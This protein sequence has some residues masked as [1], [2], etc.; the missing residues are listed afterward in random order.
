MN[1]S[2]K[3]ASRRNSK[4]GLHCTSF[5]LSWWLVDCHIL[6]LCVQFQIFEIFVSKFS[7][8]SYPRSLSTDSRKNCD[9]FA[10]GWESRIRR[11]AD[12]YWHPVWEL[13]YG[14]QRDLGY[15][16]DVRK[17]KVEVCLTKKY[18]PD[19]HRTNYSFSLILIHSYPYSLPNR[20]IGVTTADLANL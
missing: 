18:L 6:S 1:V 10:D 13:G 16:K 4:I 19:I 17:M 11:E 5:L 12:I 7:S 3:M 9:P 20:F 8:H 14:K 2:L 15:G